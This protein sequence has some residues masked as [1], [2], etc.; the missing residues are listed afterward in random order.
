MADAWRTEARN[1]EVMT[2]PKDSTQREVSG[3]TPG[4]WAFNSPLVEADG[5][6]VAEVACAETCGDDS[7]DS[8]ASAEVV[9]N[10]NLLAAA[11][12]LL[13]ACER[14]LSFVGS[15]PESDNV[16]LADFLAKVIAKAEGRGQC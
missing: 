16:G 4:P 10:G 2:A 9:A 1:G 3:H 8:A 11:P 7:I 6:T 12:D 14:A 5:S 13:E 15:M